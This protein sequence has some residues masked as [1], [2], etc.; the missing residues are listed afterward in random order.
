MIAPL[1]PEALVLETD[2]LILRPFALNDTDLAVALWC[3]PDIMRYIGAPDAQ[4]GG[5]EVG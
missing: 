1:S 2:R 3:D 4:A 5:S